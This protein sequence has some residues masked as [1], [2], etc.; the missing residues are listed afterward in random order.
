MSS[1]FLNQ[2]N[3]RVFSFE[4]IQILEKA[5]SFIFNFFNLENFICFI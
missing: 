4:L 3:F 1:I 5:K 2:I